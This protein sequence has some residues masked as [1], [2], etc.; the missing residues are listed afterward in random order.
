[1]NTDHNPLPARDAE[2]DEA[3]AGMSS[4]FDAALRAELVEAASS[5]Q[6]NRARGYGAGGRRPW[7]WRVT[8]AV[9]L[10]AAGGTAYALSTVLPGG[11]EVTGRSTLTTTAYTGSAV[12]DLGPAP[13]GATSIELGV[14]CL[15]AGSFR[16]PDG[17]GASCSGPQAWAPDGRAPTI[18][19][20][21]ITPGQHTIRVI[22][23]PATRWEAQTRYITERVTSWAVNANGQTYGVVNDHGEPDLQAVIATNGRQGYVFTRDL[24]AAGGP[25]PTDPADAATRSPVDATIPVYESD[26][27]TRIG[28]FHIGG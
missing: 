7:R 27:V 1:M 4:S 26:G 19:R 15:T 28:D 6:L 8:G 2:R 21:P 18:A 25:P 17:S 12:I 13:S 24:N 16:F 11:T 14:R 5:S 3:G 20:F 23:G 9:A 22:A 10:L